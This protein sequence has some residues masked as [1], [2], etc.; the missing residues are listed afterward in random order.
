MQSTIQKWG[1]SQGI[2]LPRQLLEAAGIPVPAD[3]PVAVEIAVENNRITISGT[4]PQKRRGIQE[5]FS[6]Y[7]GEYESFE[8][9]WGSAE[10]K[11]IW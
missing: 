5:L 11:E 6:Q 3:E 1:D 2:Q 9:D 7:T 8:M 10:G 4:A